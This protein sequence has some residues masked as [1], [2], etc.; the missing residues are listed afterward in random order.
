M[1]LETFHGDRTNSLCAAAYKEFEYIMNN[2]WNFLLVHFNG[3]RLL[4]VITKDFYFTLEINFPEYL[5]VIFRRLDDSF[6]KG[7]NYMNGA[8]FKHNMKNKLGN[9]T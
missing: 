4:Y 8:G 3:F 5:T 2:G 1:L 6:V 9:Y 7:R